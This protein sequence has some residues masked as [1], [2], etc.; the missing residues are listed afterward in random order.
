MSYKYTLAFIKRNDQILMMNR[1]KSPWMGM[2]NGIGGKRQENETPLECIMRE[3]LEETGIKVEASQVKDKG[4]LTWNDEFKAYDNGM[5][6]FY[7]ELPSNF[8]L[9]TPI[10]TDEGILEWKT[11]SWLCDIENLGVS[12]NIRYFLDNLLNDD[13]RYHYINT[14]KGN[15]LVDVKVV[16]I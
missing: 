2:W 15:Q 5:H 9:E 12:Y 10:S 13:Q 1:L 8:I 11:P 4:I 6:I 16:K 7:V 3:I 14:F